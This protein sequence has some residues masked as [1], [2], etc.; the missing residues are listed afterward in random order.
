MA[1]GHTRVGDA[2]ML[3]LEALAPFVAGHMAAKH[4]DAWRDFVSWP[5]GEYERTDLDLYTA[6]KT[7]IDQWKSIFS[8]QFTGNRN[9]R[10]IVGVALGVRNAHNHANRRFNDF[11]ALNALGVLISLLEVLPE[12]TQLND[13]RVLWNAQRAV[14]VGVSSLPD[15]GAPGNDMGS[16]LPRQLDTGARHTLIV[17][18]SGEQEFV[19]T[20]YGTTRV[21]RRNLRGATDP[22]GYEELA[23][24]DIE[25]RGLADQILVELKGGGQECRVD[26][27]ALRLGKP[28]AISAGK[29]DL[30]VA[31]L[32]L[33][34]T[35]E[36]ADC[37]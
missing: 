30:M 23:G 3:T 13:V 28:I 19:R 31:G 22:S 24:V 35:T 7:V 32:S 15:A 25:I 18:L 21:L 27:R 5:E 37:L 1:D 26:G 12:G 10:N 8:R 17:Q 14:P 29:H 4:G 9:A 16:F 6:L 2:L 33:R 34:L 11:Q 36:W 20:Y